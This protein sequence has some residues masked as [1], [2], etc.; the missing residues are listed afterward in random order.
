M[1]NLPT[2]DSK[3]DK[4]AFDE[5]FA[6]PYIGA[7]VYIAG[8]CFLS[9]TIAMLSRAGCKRSETVKDADLV[10][11]LG[12]E[13]VHPSYY[14][15]KEMAGCYY[16]IERDKREAL[17]FDEAVKWDVP[18]FGICR[19]MQLLHALTGS[20]LYHD[21]DN[22]TRSHLI[23][24]LETGERF[25]ASSMHHQMCIEDGKQIPVALSYGIS[26]LYRGP[27]ITLFDD[28][29]RELEA[30]FYPEV[31]AFGVQGHPEVGGYDRFTQWSLEHVERLLYD[32]DLPTSI[33]AFINTPAKEKV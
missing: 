26:K 18:M 17:V 24:D 10:V 9:G 27:G 25:T 20:K 29:K 19:G 33:P 2:N 1:R 32:E 13:D 30:A 5:A 11:F 23:T 6:A 31:R 21:V 7:M 14:G 22:H 16:N 3:S 4:K 15:E 28:R 12:G 8:Q